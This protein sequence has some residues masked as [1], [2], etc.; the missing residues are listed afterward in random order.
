MMTLMTTDIIKHKVDLDININWMHN[1]DQIELT[2]K[3]GQW[4]QS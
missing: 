4:Q 1:W 2:E 3:K